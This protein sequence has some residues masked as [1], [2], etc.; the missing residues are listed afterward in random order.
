MIETAVRLRSSNLATSVLEVLNPPEL[1]T[2]S[3]SRLTSRPMSAYSIDTFGE[4]EPFLDNEWLLTNG[5]GGFAMGTVVGC[6]TRRYH[7]LLVAATQP[8]VGRVDTL[9]RIGEM[10]ILDGNKDQ[11]HEL[12]V[13]HFRD[14]VHPHGEQYLK[15]FEL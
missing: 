14:N 4:L 2:T 1:S 9:N 10:L 6:N 7:G 3:P 8:P 12:A 13:N 11:P 15:R 5:L